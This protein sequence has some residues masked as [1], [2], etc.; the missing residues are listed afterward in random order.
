MRI[1]TIILSIICSFSLLNAQMN[2]EVKLQSAEDSLSYCL[3]ISIGH[4]LSGQGVEGLNVAIISAAMEGVFDKNSTLFNK[5]DAENFIRDYFSKMQT[6]KYSGNLEQANKFLSENKKVKG[7][8]E[9]PSGLQY[10]ILEEGSGES[11][12]ENSQVKTHYKGTFIDGGVFDSSYDRG[13]PAV[14][15]VNGVI[16]GW[17]EALLLMKPGAKWQLFIPPHLAYGEKGAGGQIPPNTALIFEIELL[18]V[19]N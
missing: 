17:T 7:V 2:K 11:P 13:E 1:R 15:P 14:F 6:S 4:G 19:I 10:M 8:V 3:G 18:E 5:I 16:K 12:T 9:L